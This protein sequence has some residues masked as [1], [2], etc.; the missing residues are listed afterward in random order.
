[1]F[2]FCLWICLCLKKREKNGMCLCF[3][4]TQAHLFSLSSNGRAHKYVCGDAGSIPAV[5]LFNSYFFFV[6]VW[7]CLQLCVFVFVCVF[8]EFAL[9]VCRCVW[10]FYCFMCTFCFVCVFYICHNS[11]QSKRYQL[12]YINILF[13]YFT[14]EK[15]VQKKDKK[16]IKKVLKKY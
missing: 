10:F 3:M 2:L 7:V 8:C 14:A 1:M 12:K 9:L 16:S 13:L 11:I 6:A 4:E 5:R 15:K